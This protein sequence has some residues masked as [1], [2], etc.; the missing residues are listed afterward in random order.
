MLERKLNH[1]LPLLGHGVYALP[2]GILVLKLIPDLLG[3]ALVEIDDYAGN[4]FA[5]DQ[6]MNHGVTITQRQIGARED[7]A[8]GEIVI[9]LLLPVLRAQPWRVA[10]S[11]VLFC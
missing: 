4:S 5:V 2:A 10:N 7:D 8:A 3:M 11:S 1:V 6:L 9:V